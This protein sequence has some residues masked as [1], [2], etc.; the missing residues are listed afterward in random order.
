MFFDDRIKSIKPS[1]KVLE[2][3]PGAT[4]FWRSDIF[5]E[6]IF[7]T[8]NELVA[9]SGHVGLLKTEKMV[10]Y[11]SGD[12]FP[13]EDKEFDYVICSHV[14]EHVADVDI[15][16]KEI[17]RVAKRGYLEFPTIYYDYV[18]NF[19]EHTQFLFFKENIIY[20]MPKSR[21]SLN[22]FADVQRFFHKSC[23]QHNYGLIN[24]N[25][26]YFF[27]G[28]EWDSIIKTEK[29]NEIKILTYLDSELDFELKVKSEVS[30]DFKQKVKNFLIKIINKI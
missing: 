4:P 27:Q 24:E 6:K 2:V 25:K 10:H 14:L 13:F 7:G 22:D 11:Y 16:I 20:W 12:R 21:S 3:G 28:F 26:D 18:Y 30:N 23:S 19:P 29:V 9:Q 1:D 5:L 15:F 17:Q 8:E